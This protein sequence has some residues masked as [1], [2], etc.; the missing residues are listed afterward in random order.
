MGNIKNL[1]VV[2]IRRIKSK[3]ELS[4]L[5]FKQ[6]GRY[7]DINSYNSRE[8]TEMS[9]GIYTHSKVLLVDGD[10]FLDLK[11][12]SGC[13]C[14]LAD[15]S[16]VKTPVF[17]DINDNSHNRIGN[18]RTYYVKDYFLTTE[19]PV[20]GNTEHRITRYLFRTKHLRKG[21]G[22]FSTLF[23]ISNDYK[24]FQSFKGGDY[25]K[26]LF[27]PIKRGVNGMFFDDDYFISNFRVESSIKLER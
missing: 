15:V 17:R 12:V 10:Y 21:R 3:P 26:D 27:H 7:P 4:G 20:S 8:I 11:L 19:H 18:I 23:S 9:I 1:S 25:P 14:I 22:R 5:A 2:E 24:A 13:K 6:F 16:Y